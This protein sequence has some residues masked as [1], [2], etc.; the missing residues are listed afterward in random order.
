[1]NYYTNNTNLGK[2]N[3]KFMSGMD[4]DKYVNNKLS[5]QLGWIKDCG[6]KAQGKDTMNC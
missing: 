2:F 4:F 5:K 6:S 1:M 3:K